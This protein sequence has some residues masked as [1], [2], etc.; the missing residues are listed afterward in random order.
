MS[1]SRGEFPAPAPSAPTLVA[2][3]ERAARHPGVVLRFLDASEREEILTW[4]EVRDRALGVAGALR[5]LGIEPGERV[6][7]VHPTCPDFVVSLF[8]VLL[9]GAV[10]VPLYPPVRLGRLDEY[11]RRTAAMLLASGS[12]L[13]LADARVRRILGRT[14]ELAPPSLG[15][16]RLSDLTPSSVEP[17]E[18]RPEDLGL[19]QFSSGT[20]VDPKP[21]ALSHRALMAQVAALN[22]HWP[23]ADGVVN[24]GFCWLPLYHDMGLVGCVFSALERPGDLTLMGPEVFVARP[25]LW[26]RGISRF[27]ATISPAPNFAYALC[28]ERVRDEDLE[29]VD[30]SSWRGALNGAESVSPRVLRAFV[31]RFAR[32]GLRPEALTPVYGLSEAALAVTF[33]ELGRPFTSR[34]FDRDALADGQGRTADDGVEI[35]SVGRPLPGFEVQLRDEAGSPVE[36]GRVGRLWARGPSLMDGYLDRR[37]ATAAALVDGW[38]DTGDLGLLVDGELHLVGRAKDVV[39]L[40]GRNYLPDEIEAALD[41]VAGARRGCAA[42]VGHLPEDGEREELLLLVEHDRKATSEELLTLPERCRR[43][44]LHET[45]LAV[46]RVEVLEPGTL[47]RTS[48]GKIRRGEALSRFLRGTLEPP[49]PVNA[50]TLG[51]A[52]AGSQVAH[53]RRRLR[54][55]DGTPSEGSSGAG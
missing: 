3:L 54:G 15:C 48:S 2:A 46:D 1:V 10:P 5:R 45:S 33:A 8:A 19:V 12:R 31:S 52:L 11:H 35:V 50:L 23:D 37:D 40:R 36:T 18:V 39:I 34:V 20:T 4:S 42:A 27:R 47:P 32:W 44:I 41:D 49:V 38:L 51:R 9:A 24:S 55:G 29:G 13:V 53:L 21:V 28:L 25:S 30:L 7:L 14:L 17:K 6:A 43:A 26:L 22:S 16:A